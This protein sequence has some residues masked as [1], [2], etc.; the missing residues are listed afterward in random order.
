MLKKRERCILCRNQYDSIES[1]GKNLCEIKLSNLDVYIGGLKESYKGLPTIYIDHVSSSEE[2]KNL[3][4]NPFFLI[5]ECNFDKIKPDQ[6]AILYKGQKPEDMNQI[7][8]WDN[9]L[10]EIVVFNVTEEYKK[11]LREEKKEFFVDADFSEIYDRKKAVLY[12]CLY[13][14]VNFYDH[15]LNEQDRQKYSNIMRLTATDFIPFIII[16]RFRRQ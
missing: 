15:L 1:Y 14:F 6:R 9:P 8:E 16:K 7:F 4:Y 12:D 2:L 11:A 5:L 10:R 13:D 3:L